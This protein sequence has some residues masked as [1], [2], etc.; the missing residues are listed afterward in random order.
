MLHHAHDRI[1]LELP[2]QLLVT[3]LQVELLYFSLFNLLVERKREER[4]EKK[5]L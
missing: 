5:K 2:M 4:S 3:L 1:V